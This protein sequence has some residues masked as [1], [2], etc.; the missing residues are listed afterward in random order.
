[1]QT[2][3]ADFPVNAMTVSTR[4]RRDIHVIIFA[5][6]VALVIIGYGLAGYTNKASLMPMKL[7]RIVFMVFSLLYLFN[8]KKDFQ[9]IFKGRASWIMWIF[10]VTNLYVVPFSTIVS[11]S[12]E[13]VINLIPFFIY[14]NYF[15]VYLNRMYDKEYSLSLLVKII[16]IVYSLPI[17]S[18]LI[19]GG[20]FSQKDIY[21]A[22]I[23]GFVSNHYG[24][25]STLFLATGFDTIKNNR[26][27]SLFY[28]LFIIGGSLPALYVLAISG[29]R[30]G[31]L[32]FTL[33]FLLFVLRNKKTNIPFKIIA[34][35]GAIYFVSQLY[36]DTDSALS[37]RIEKTET[38]VEQGDART[39]TRQ[40]GFDI[41]MEHPDRF[42]TGFGFYTFKETLLELDETGKA[43]KFTTSIHNSYLELFFG[44]GVLIFM[45]FLLFFI[46]KTIYGFTIRH[47]SMY[48]F[49]PPV[50]I[51]PY[52]ENNFN[53]GQF[54][55]FPWFAIMF[56]YI[57][58]YERQRALLV[59]EPSIDAKN[60]YENLPYWLNNR[61]GLQPT[62]KL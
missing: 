59:E 11:I 50:I 5:I 27:V 24:W 35:I 62:A 28:K 6:N 34:T 55:F 56:Y 58:Y 61:E 29:S 2:S 4:K 44:S 45:F 20:S 19:F 17:I 23:A 15:I 1:M 57:H 32:T 25:S 38:Q 39:S 12:L 7:L 16:S 21:G 51:I 33:C 36:L 46:G 40:L 41:M 10:I 3:I 42:F 48:T 13:K 8:T 60:N 9:Y 26:K 30:S 49:L 37:K 18:F 22:E 14:L 53:P 43:R 47:S 31:Y 52:F 54:L